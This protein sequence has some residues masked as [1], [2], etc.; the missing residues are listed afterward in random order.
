MTPPCAVCIIALACLASCTPS[1]T[2]T[3][4]AEYEQ[5]LFQDANVSDHAD[6]MSPIDEA[7]RVST[8]ATMTVIIRPAIEAYQRHH[9]GKVPSSLQALAEQEALGEPYLEAEHLV[10]AWGHPF[11]FTVTG[12]REFELLSYGADGVEGGEEEDADIASVD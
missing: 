12:K 7:R 11:H 1:D 8:R 4:E 5:A 6:S 9:A 3:T 2:D 10:D